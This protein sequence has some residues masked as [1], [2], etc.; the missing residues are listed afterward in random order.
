MQHN[1]ISGVI[2]YKHTLARRSWKGSWIVGGSSARMCRRWTSRRGRECG[3]RR[4][5]A[6]G[7]AQW[8]GYQ[9]TVRCTGVRC[10]DASE[11][12]QRREQAGR[13]KSRAWS[14]KLDQPL[15]APTTVP[16]QPAAIA[17]TLPTPGHPPQPS[18]TQT[19]ASLL[20]ANSARPSAK[21][22]SG[23][24]ARTSGSCCA[25]AR[26]ACNR[27]AARTP[28]RS[29]ASGTCTPSAR[30]ASAGAP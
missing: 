2:R 11:Q 28:S 17:A 18:H 8:I 14:K 3:L 20:N 26:A 7:R 13:K 19:P 15:V 25:V 4:C 29:R 6:I 27:T 12:N 22:A 5:V 23:T 30:S 24:P 16:S 1:S 21:T 9:A 10:G